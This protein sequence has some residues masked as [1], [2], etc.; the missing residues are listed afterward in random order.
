MWIRAQARTRH[1][2][3]DSFQNFD[4]SAFLETAI[5]I[6]QTRLRKLHVGCPKFNLIMSGAAT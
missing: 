4:E 1:S 5:G 6:S 3:S 2:S